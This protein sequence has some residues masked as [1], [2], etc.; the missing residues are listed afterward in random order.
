[1]IQAD[2]LSFMAAPTCRWTAS[3]LGRDPVLAPGDGILMSNADVGSLTL[4][5]TA[6]FTTFCLPRAALAPLVPDVGSVIARAV[7]AGNAALRLLV[8]YLASAFDSEVLVTPELQ[9]LVVTHV[10]DLLAVA[11][12]GARDAVEIAAGR[13]MRA[14]RLCA[15]KA[16][17]LANI[18]SSN[19][20]LDAVAERLGISPIYV[21]KLLES[22]DTSFT[23]FALEQRLVRAHRML[24]DPRFAGHTIGAVALEAGFGDI[25]YFNRTFHRRYGAAPSDVRAQ[26]RRKGED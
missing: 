5:S 20:S 3:Q 17:I 18:D 6:Q 2:D 8:G 14:A 15:I 7:P 21:R 10:Y 16:D 11:L 25:S 1:L 26:A 9:Q 13:G 12:G 24:S 4:G 19:L 22:E 23:K